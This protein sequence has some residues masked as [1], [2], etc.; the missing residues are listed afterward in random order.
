MPRKQTTA[1]SSAA[2][3]LVELPAIPRPDETNT[4]AAL[5]TLEQAKAFRIANN[6]GRDAAC[7]RMLATKSAWQ[8]LEDE[9][10]TMKAPILEAGKKVDNFFRGALSALAQSEQLYKTEISRYDTEVEEKAKAEQ[11]RLEEIAR[12]E[13]ERK[14]AAAREAERKAAEKAE[15]AR[16]EADAKRKAEDDARKAADEAR[17]RGDREAAAAAQRQA[18]EAA[19]AAVRLE[20]KAE[21]TEAAGQIKAVALHGQAQ[22]IV[23]PVVRATPP[24]FAG[25]SSAQVWDFEITDENKINRPFMT[26]DL[27]KIRKQVAAMKQHAGAIIGEGIRI[28]PA[29][30]ISGRT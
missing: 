15:T 8:Q 30:R 9:R 7:A 16:R 1:A 20:N 12:K 10:V 13:R 26:P 18:E 2:A 21:R 25:V 14:E 11:R 23:A 19:R 29:K 5:S 6:D 3:N 22:T 28:F 27:A 24:K 4:T 17:A